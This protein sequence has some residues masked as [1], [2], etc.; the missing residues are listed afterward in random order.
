MD[1]T[2]LYFFRANIRNMG[3][4]YVHLATHTGRPG[5]A[6][7]FSKLSGSEGY[8]FFTH[9][10]LKQYA[11]IV[12]PIKFVATHGYL[13]SYSTESPSEALNAI[14]NGND[15]IGIEFGG[16]GLGFPTARFKRPDT[17]DNVV[18]KLSS[19]FVYLNDVDGAASGKLGV[20][21]TGSALALQS[22]FKL[23]ESLSELV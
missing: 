3:H 18:A 5:P 4:K 20:K 6:K 21:K 1:C 23:I 15:S 22:K 16:E 13:H 11:K 10:Q 8:S 14:N 12:T 17:N 2:C 19:G 7:V 9:A